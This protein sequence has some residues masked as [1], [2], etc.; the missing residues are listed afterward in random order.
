MKLTLQTQLLPNEV[1][2]ELMGQTVE[3]FNAACSW[4]AAQA[5]K[6]R[7]SNKVKLQRLYYRILPSHSRAKM[8]NGTST[9]A[10]PPDCT[11]TSYSTR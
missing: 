7:L 2:S 6:A 5:F 3:R 9:N 4:L 1:Q 10:Q 11:S 8:N